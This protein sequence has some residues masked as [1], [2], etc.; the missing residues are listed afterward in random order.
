M[1]LVTCYPHSPTAQA[2]GRIVRALLAEDLARAASAPVP[3]A[4]NG[5]LRI[6]VPVAQGQLAAHFGHCER[7][8]IFDVSSERKTIEHQELVTPPHHELGTQIVITGGMGV[9]AQ[10]LFT[11][12][13]ITVIAGAAV[14]DPEAIVRA[15]LGGELETGPNACDH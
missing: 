5:K 13:G 4:A 3:V 2:F 1:P 9:R 14:A 7:F 8:A 15:Y 12:Q 10:S 6:A 11:K